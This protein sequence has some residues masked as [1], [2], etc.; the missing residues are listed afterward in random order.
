[1]AT[2]ELR[3]RINQDGTLTV[4]V[5]RA[6]EHIDGNLPRADVFD[7]VK[8]AAISKGVFVRDPDLVELLMEAV[9]ERNDVGS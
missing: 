6:V 8:Y 2:R 7:R 9:R 3:L 1:M 4:R 5:G